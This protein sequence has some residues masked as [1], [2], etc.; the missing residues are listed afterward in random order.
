MVNSV[1]KY[2]SV[3]HLI[4]VSVLALDPPAVRMNYGFSMFLAV[5]ILG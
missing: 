5:T 1:E 4:I 3:L 2:S